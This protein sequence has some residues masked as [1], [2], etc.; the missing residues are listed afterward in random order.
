MSYKISI[1]SYP[2]IFA[3]Y[4][5]IISLKN[6]SCANILC[7]NRQALLSYAHCNDIQGN[8]NLAIEIV[9]SIILKG[10]IALRII[11]STA[12]ST[13][14]KSANIIFKMK[15]Y[16]LLCT[17]RSIKNMYYVFSIYKKKKSI[18]IKIFLFSSL[19]ICCSRIRV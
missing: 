18:S 10:L 6:D 19:L 8:A 12:C 17:N 2:F 4:I 1:L 5:S 3:L 7:G 15:E 13:L 11:L 14:W 9:I 16:F